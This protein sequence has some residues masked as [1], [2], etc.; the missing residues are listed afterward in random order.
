MIIKILIATA[1]IFPVFF[2]GCT[3]LNASQSTVSGHAAPTVDAYVAEVCALYG[4][5]IV[6]QTE[7]KTR[8]ICRLS[9]GWAVDALALER[10]VAKIMIDGDT[11]KTPIQPPYFK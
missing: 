4:G 11:L 6:F 7:D 1:I 8:P 3:Q 10:A 5:K 2:A 9:D